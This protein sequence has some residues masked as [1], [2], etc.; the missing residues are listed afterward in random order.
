MR[1]RAF[2][3]FCIGFGL[4]RYDLLSSG[5]AGDVTAFVVEED[6][7]RFAQGLLEVFASVHL[8]VAPSQTNLLP[9]DTSN[10]KSTANRLKKMGFTGNFDSTLIQ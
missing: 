2:Y 4:S 10:S 1:A 8:V 3:A 6:V 7:D 9:M 5:D